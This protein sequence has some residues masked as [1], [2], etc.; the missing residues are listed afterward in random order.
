M[1]F[2]KIAGVCFILLFLF[3]GCHNKKIREESERIED[4]IVD[5]ACNIVRLHDTVM[6]KEY[7][8]DDKFKIL[9]IMNGDCDCILGSLMDFNVLIKNEKFKCFKN[10]V[11]VEGKNLYAFDKFMLHRNMYGN[12]AFFRD[13]EGEFCVKNK[14][15]YSDFTLCLLDGNNSV[16]FCGDPIYNL[17]EE[18]EFK[19]LIE[20]L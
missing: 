18:K 5:F 4:R 7:M 3:V 20:G 16:L 17:K 19:S 8:R 11:V 1:S 13:V 6:M 14:I 2:F 12:M 9:A 15:E 10:C